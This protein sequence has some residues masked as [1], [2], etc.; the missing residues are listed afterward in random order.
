[1]KIVSHRGNLDGEN[2]KLENHP[3]QI[4]LAIRNN[5]L[6]EVDLRIVN[7]RF[8]LG[9]DTSDYLIDKQWLL[10]RKQYLI[11]HSKDLLTSNHLVRLNKE[12]NWFYHTDED[13]VL[14]S[15]GWIWCYPGIYLSEGITVLIGD[16]VKLPSKVLGVCTDYPIKFRSSRYKE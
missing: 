11:I 10:Y 12:L 3:D 5:F 1:M 2:P 13:I 8:F 9:H 14:S 4:D 16:Q 6:V 7:D 15:W